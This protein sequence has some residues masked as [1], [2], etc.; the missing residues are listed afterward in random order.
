M[1]MERKDDLKEQ[2]SL[3][4]E[5]DS[6]MDEELADYIKG[7]NIDV[8]SINKFS[9]KLEDITNEHAKNFRKRVKSAP[10]S[11]RQ[12]KATKMENG[13][14]MIRYGK[15]S[16]KISAAHF[17]KMNC[18]YELNTN[19][20]SKS[21]EFINALFGCILRY[22]TFQGGG[23]Q[24]AVHGEV[25]DVLLKYF[26]TDFECFASPFNARYPSYC[27]AFPDTDHVFGGKSDFFHFKPLEGSFEANP[28]FVPPLVESMAFH[29]NGLLAASE[30]KE[31][32]LMFVVIIQNF[33]EKARCLEGLRESC[34]LTSKL[35]LTQKDHGF[36]EGKQQ[37]RPTRFRIS[38]SDT[39]VF[40]LQTAPAKTRWPVTEK[41]LEDLKS[42]FASKQREEMKEKDVFSKRKTKS[43]ETE[44]NA[45]RKK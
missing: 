34:Y 5:V 16:V 1:K 9:K 33:G 3:L 14:W 26:G 38:S 44:K 24:A 37:I 17:E 12:A 7:F 31:K 15:R 4:F 30:D 6:V 21:N 32:G 25:F 28:P 41:S 20:K 19:K 10:T 27:S 22:E 2:D 45:K 11:F 43:A 18:M 8:P 23:F 42:A 39:I 40:F 35:E 29:I 13:F 36:C